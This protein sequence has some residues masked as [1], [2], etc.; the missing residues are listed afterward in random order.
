MRIAGKELPKNKN[1]EI[2]LTYIYGIGRS[3]AKK[4]LEAVKVD[5]LKKVKDLTEEE[6]R[7]IR[8]YIER[9]FKVE[10]DLK[11]EVERNIRRLKD[12]RC[13]RGIRHLKGLPVR[14][15]KTRK[16]ARTRKGKRITVGSGKKKP[17]APK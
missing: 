13:Y 6:Q 16:N 17:P 8:E 15:Q 11:L 7:K 1:V 10:A 5:P 3:L 12:I 2:A 9:N 4:T 14:G